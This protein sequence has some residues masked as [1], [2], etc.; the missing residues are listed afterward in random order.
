MKA[1][2]ALLKPWTD[3]SPALRWVLCLGL[4]VGV[5]QMAFYMQVLNEQM[6]RADQVR[7]GQHTP[8]VAPIA[9]TVVLPH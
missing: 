9:V 2:I 7:L 8:S 1:W 4:F 3:L 5:C 6:V